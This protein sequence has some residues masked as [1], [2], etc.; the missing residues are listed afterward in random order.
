MRELGLGRL[1]DLPKLSDLGNNINLCQQALTLSEDSVEFEVLVYKKQYKM[2]NC[3]ASLS[4]YFYLASPMAERV[5]SPPA[6]QETQEPRVRPPGGRRKGQ[7][8]PGP[9]PGK[10]HR[11]R[12]LAG[13]STCGRKELGMTEHSGTP[14]LKSTSRNLAVVPNKSLNH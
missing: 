1:W 8:T 6:M 12:S 3:S 5:K 11:Q 4:F 7:P 13:C 10:P 14:T 9:L 2:S